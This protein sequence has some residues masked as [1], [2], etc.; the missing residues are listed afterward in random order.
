MIV[1]VVGSGAVGGYYGARLVQA[2]AE[3]RFLYRSELE[4]V[5]R[6]GL[7]I[8]SVD[9]N[10]HGM[11]QAFGSAREMGRCDVVLVCLK[12]AQTAQFA[13]LIQPV[14]GPE[15]LVVCLMNGLGHEE[16]IAQIS[17]PGAVAAGAAFICAE[18]GQ[19]GTV[20]HFAAGGL[21]VGAYFPED[22]G[23]VLARCR[24]LS[25]MFS[26]SGVPCRVEDD[27]RAVKWGKLVWNV[28]FSGLSIWAGGITTDRILADEALRSF[29]ADLMDEVFVAAEAAASNWIGV[30]RNGTST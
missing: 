18:R 27:G 20:R 16:R 8:D 24:N 30:P 17:G 14:L 12:S 23:D 21:S 25:S 22:R 11:V 5:R 3:V 4:V 9:G 15:T 19:P 13:E 29:A 28:P 26:R 6:N 2:G 7:R 10:W 1:G